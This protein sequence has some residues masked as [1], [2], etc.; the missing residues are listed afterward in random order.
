MTEKGVQ[1][2]KNENF[3]EWYTQVVKE[4]ELADQR[5]GVQ[6]FI[7]HQPLSVHLSRKI[8]SYFED[9]VESD[10]HEPMLLPSIIPE[11]NLDKE[12]EHADFAPEVF[13]VTK[14]G[15]DELERDFALRPTGETQIY[16]MY[17]KWIRSHNQLPFKRY[18]SRIS[19]FRY[20][21]TTRP[22]LRGREFMFFETHDVF[23]D[24]DQALDQIEKDMNMMKKVVKDKL[25]IPFLFFERPQWDK[26]PGAESTFASDTLLPNGKRNQIS[27]THD[28]GHKFAKAFDVTYTDEDGEEKYG[29]QTCF[30]PGVWRLIAS[31][32]AIHG[33]DQ[34]L[35]LPF[36][37]GKPQIII[38]PILFSDDEEQNQ[39]TLDYSEKVKEDLNDYDVRIDSRDLNPG[40]K[41]NHW[42]LRGV[43][44]RLEVGPDEVDEGTVT[45]VRRVDGERDTVDAD[46]HVL[47]KEVEAHKE[48]LNKKIKE[49]AEKE[50][51][52][53]IKYASTLEE[54]KDI[55]E[56]HRGFIKAPFCSMDMTGEE[57]ADILKDETT[58]EVCGIPLGED[59]E[60][61]DDTCI[62]C[63]DEASYEV[64][65][66]KSI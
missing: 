45:L 42:E 32:I 11:E 64:Y 12:E 17:S 63:D 20:E 13:W 3:S 10:G 28:L 5:Y 47:N 59:E 31:L 21:S 37:L 24:H 39:E 23:Q 33:D 40:E 54:V 48:E 60:P 4:A 25:L 30:G 41:F 34:G 53:N 62:V 9:E 14:G 55:I 1:A 56:E 52:K 8:Y 66:A 44:I 35:V 18:Q 65:I 36:E 49:R 51:N 7:V 61:V 57:C 2:K 29:Y 58:A 43:P 46:K 38:T 6:G 26:F 16:P 19:S 22:F 15:S 27:S 50:F